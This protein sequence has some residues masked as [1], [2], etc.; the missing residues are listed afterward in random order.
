LSILIEHPLPFVEEYLNLLNKELYRYYP[1][2]SLSRNQKLWLGFCLS[3]VIVT[4]K[5][6]W[7]SF[8][9]ASLGKFGQRSLSWMFCHSKIFWEEL[10]KVSVLK[11]LHNYGITEGVLC[12]DDV[13]RNRSKST[14]QIYG[15]HKLK[16]KLTGGF[17]DGQCLGF[18]FLITAKA[19]FPV[20]FDFYIPNPKWKAWKKEDDRLKKQKIARNIVLLNRSVIRITQQKSKL[21]STYCKPSVQIF[22]TSRSNAS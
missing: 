12:C 20:G 7:K 9:C 4:N 1:G 3:A 22:Q 16:D 17:I 19:S 18:L 14:T 13:D 2:C 15:V 11:I 6:C 5:I 10:F 8:A 21:L